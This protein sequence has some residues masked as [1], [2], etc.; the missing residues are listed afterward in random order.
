[1]ILRAEYNLTFLLILALAG[2][3]LAGT[4]LAGTDVE[5]IDI[6]PGEPLP[7]DQG[8]D[9]KEYCFTPQPEEAYSEGWFYMIRFDDGTF[10]F[11]QFLVT[12]IG[13]GSRNANMN[14]SVN[15]PD[16]TSYF[17]RAEFSKETFE[18][19]EDSF[20]VKV[21]DSY[22][23]GGYPEVKMRLRL[24]DI[25]ADLD[26]AMELPG[27]KPGGGVL[28][29]GEDRKKFYTMWVGVPRGRVTGTL[30]I[31]NEKR[32]VA[33]YGYSDHSVV[34]L[35]PHH[36]S[37]TW[38]S[39]RAFD[40]HWTVEYLEF[41]TPEKYGSKRVPW[42]LIGKDGK[43]LY[44]GMDY[45]LETSDFRID[46]EIELDYPGRLDFTVDRPEIK[47]SGTVKIKNKIEAINMLTKM[48]P[49]ERVVAGFF[50]RSYVI[51]LRNEV[52]V[53]ITTPESSDTLSLQ[54]VSEKLWM[55]P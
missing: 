48:R 13:F 8:L 51:R 45:T 9:P 55:N 23:C 49:L 43:I 31:R 36:Y 53:V 12:N 24:K 18:A 21:G 15:Y 7:F 44:A 39:L 2:S 38:F 29:F 5:P 47:V 37:R 40:E 17:E 41:F 54:G 25:R 28:Y 14:V 11:C 1:M 30:Q 32:K 46:P 52:D 3:A 50:A 4:A 16:G 6:Y 22:I 33:G 20:F 26:I 10:L 42:I 34:N 19:S 35:Y 27:W